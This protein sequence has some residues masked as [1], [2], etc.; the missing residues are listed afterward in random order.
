MRMLRMAMRHESGTRAESSRVS[1]RNVGLAV[2]FMLTVAV[3]AAQAEG[4]W[5]WGNSQSGTTSGTDPHAASPRAIPPHSPG[6]LGIQF[7]DMS[8]EQATLLHLKGKS[9]VEVIN[10]D[11]D[12][13]A[14]K[15]GLR[16][17]DVILKL[18]GQ[19]VVSAE[20]LRRMIHD[21]GVGAGVA[22]LLVRGGQQVTV[23][24]QL[25][26]RGEV[27]REAIARMVLPEAPTGD[28]PIVAG[29]VETYEVDPAA[30]SGAAKSPGFLAQML[31]T[32]PFTGMVVEAIAPQLAGFF[33]SSTG[34]GLLVETVA[35][36]S[37]AAAAGLRA[38]DVV[39]RAD[40]IAVKSPS[41]WV[42]RLHAS[43]GQAILLIV[44][45]DKREIPMTLIPQLKKHSMLEW[46]V[47]F[48]ELT[49]VA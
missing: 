42:K 13:P 37:P 24:A 8:E 29:F 33:G 38:G 45:R 22:L 26:Y 46:P 36:G 43:K 28:D 30:P 3:V 49:L 34:G 19:V 20:M 18:N 44:L 11:H 25:A 32:T 4:I 21:A 40:S 5:L 39:E 12:G 14:G 31:H 35:A 10:V 2:G 1:L 6:Y 15:A 47:G 17:H 27:E 7:A 16:P 41:E 23:N 48:G 9:G